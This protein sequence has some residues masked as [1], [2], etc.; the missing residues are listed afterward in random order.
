M[1]HDD[2]LLTSQEM[3]QVRKVPVSRLHKERLFG[4]D[5]QPFIKDGHLVRYRWGDYIAWLAA[6]QRFHSTSELE[7]A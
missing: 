6:K 2:D 5:A 4:V 7:A 1:R 3:A